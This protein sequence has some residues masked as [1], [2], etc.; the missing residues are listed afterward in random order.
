MSSNM[1]FLAVLAALS[2]PACAAPSKVMVA[3][4]FSGDDKVAKTLIL[5]GGQVDPS[6]KQRLFNVYVRIC[7][8][9]PKNNES[10]CKDTTVLQNVVP[11]TVY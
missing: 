6:T 2:L 5:D 11:G 4:G 7:D 8:I 1:R 10:K 3:N 9:D